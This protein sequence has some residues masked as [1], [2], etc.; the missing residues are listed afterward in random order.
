MG[1]VRCR[2]LFYRSRHHAHVCPRPPH[3]FRPCAR[4]GSWPGCAN[5]FN[6]CVTARGRRKSTSTGIGQSSGS[7]G[8]AIRWRWAGSGSSFRGAPGHG[9]PG[10]GID[11]PAGFV[12]PTVP[13]DGKALEAQPLCM[14]KTDQPLSK[15]HLP[16]V[17]TAV[18]SKLDKVVAVPP[19]LDGLRCPLAGLLY[20]RACGPPRH[21]SPKSPDISRRTGAAVPTLP[22]HKP[23]H[24]RQRLAAQRGARH[25]AS[26]GNNSR[27]NRSISRSN[28]WYCSMKSS[29]PASWKAAMRCATS[30]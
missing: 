18:V 22:R 30:S 21:C 28:G 15:P 29:M 20:G 17:P 12:R 19:G 2:H 6:P 10:A 4:P 9:S 7:M 11:A 3:R 24:A 27:A 23:A 26:R 8:C 5:A 25:G 13:V 16:V 1:S 14:A